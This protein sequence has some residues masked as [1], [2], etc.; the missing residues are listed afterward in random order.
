VLRSRAVESSGPAPVF[1][2]EV[3]G[4]PQTRQRAELPWDEAQRRR[5]RFWLAVSS[6]LTLALVLAL[7]LLARLAG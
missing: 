7:Y 5:L 4:R 2:V 1:E 6:V 3:A